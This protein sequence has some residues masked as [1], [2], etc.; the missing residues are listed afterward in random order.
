M[1]LI[2]GVMNKKRNYVEEILSKSERNKRRPAY[3]LLQNRIDALEKALGFAEESARNG[4]PSGTE[5][6]KYIPIGLVACAEGFLR[7]SFK[8]II[9]FG[10]P[11]SENAA[12]FQQLKFDFKLVQAI[13]T[14]TVTVGDFVSHLLP[15]NNLDDINA[16]LTTLI[17]EDFL[18]RFKSVQMTAAKPEDADA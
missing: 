3:W 1:N 17:G 10:P 18:N 7:L 16:N 12:S 4:D 6:L 5:L 2:G 14:R 13:G 9:D 11:F 15:L 8:E